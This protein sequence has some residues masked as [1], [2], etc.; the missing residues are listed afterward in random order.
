M[1]GSD[2]IADSGLSEPPSDPSAL[3]GLPAARH[4]ERLHRVSEYVRPWWYSSVTAFDERSG[5]RFDLL[6]PQ[7]TCYLAE[8]LDGALVEKLLRARTKVVVAERLAELFHAT[9]HVRAA[10]AAADLTSRRA[11]AA[12]LNAEVHTT[13]DYRITRRWARALRRAGWRGLRYL[14]RGDVSGSAAG[15]AVFGRAGLHR[16]APAGLTTEVA[17]LDRDRAE[18]LLHE[19][20]VEVRPIPTQVPIAPPPTDPTGQ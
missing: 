14:L 7:G 10:P 11:T 2:P 8:S 15:R 6:T 16:R 18:Q 3:T 20:G 17:P 12:G 4:V 5:G 13:L 9:I 19:R 1:T